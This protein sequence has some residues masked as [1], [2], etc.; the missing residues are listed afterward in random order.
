ML[1]T[2][3]VS[4]AQAENYYTQ[5]DYYTQEESDASHWFGKGAIALGISGTVDQ[6]TFQRLLHGKTP[7]GQSLSGKRID[8]SQR[9][10]ATDYTF[11][12]PKSVSIAALVQQDARVLQAHHHAVTQALAVLES[13][14]AQ[15]RVSTSTGRHRVVTG[16]LVA[17]IFPHTTSR[18]MEPQLHSH[19]VVINATQLPDGQ[20]RSFSNEEAI[21][22]Q[23]LLG[24]IYQNELVV[25]LR[26]QGYQIELRP[27]GQFELVDYSP[28]LRNL[29][30][31]RRQQV[32]SLLAT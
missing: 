2:S 4:A 26:Q 8:S 9:R 30:S 25:A 28:E 1:S 10:A 23:K 20:W 18:A 7:N 27:H 14:Y 21:A 17:A 6:F 16:N 29:F 12:A 5:E 32:K 15:T 3:N 31:T 11:S 19:C 13:R 22:N 24:Q